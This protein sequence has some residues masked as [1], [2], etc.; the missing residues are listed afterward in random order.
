MKRFVYLI[1]G[2]LACFAVTAA[3]QYDIEKED[4]AVYSS[5]LYVGTPSQTTVSWTMGEILDRNV[6]DRKLIHYTDLYGDQYVA[7]VINMG[8]SVLKVSM[9]GYGVA[10]VTIQPGFST[11]FSGT[12]P[13]IE[14]SLPFYVSVDGGGSGSVRIICT[15]Q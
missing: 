9:V 10:E 7:N 3:S 6:N 1:V 14:T 4:L 5:D 8:S 11:G 15:S 2:L 12:K 13:S